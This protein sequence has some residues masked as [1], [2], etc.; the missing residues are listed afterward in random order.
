VTAKWAIATCALLAGCVSQIGGDRETA[1][2]DAAEAP[3][4]STPAI[5]AAVPDAPA[6]AP[7][8][9]RV[10]FLNF[11]GDTVARSAQGDAR[12]DSAAWVGLSTGQASATMAE[13]RPTASDRASQIAEVVAELQARF[14]TIA[15]TMQFVTTRP[16]AGAYVM[17]G[18]GGSMQAAGVPYTGAVATL[19]CGDANKNDVGWVFESTTSPTMVVNY[20]AGAIGYSMGATGTTDSNDCMC[21]WLTSCQPSGNACTFSSA[22]NAQLACAGQTDPQDDVG[23]LASFCTSPQ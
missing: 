3:D 12:A 8:C 7:G 9:G 1:T 6:D 23:L 11:G 16:T 14:S 2:H 18:F 4:A 10:V 22:A 19:D 20:A 17:I 21:G 13:W 15:P 5:D